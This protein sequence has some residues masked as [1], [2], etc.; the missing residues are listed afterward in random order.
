M[1]G[2]TSD[3]DGNYRIENVAVGRHNIKVSYIGYEDVYFNEIELIT[4][5]ELVLNVQMTEDISTLNEV[6]IK[7][8]DEMGEPINSMVTLSAQ[9]ITIESTSRIAA[10][11]NDPA[12]TV[13]SFAG[14]SSADDE[15]N[16]LVVRGNSPRGMLWRMEGVEIPNPNHFSNGEGGSGGG[17]S[18]LST[19]VLDNSD[20]YTGAFASEYGN[21]LSGVFD[22]RLRN[23]NNEKHQFALQLGVMGIQA[24]AEGPLSK[25]SG[26]SY[27]FNYRYATTSLLNE[28]GFTIGDEDIY[29]EWQDL[30]FNVNI[31][32]KKTGQVQYLGFGR[33]QR[34]CR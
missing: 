11:I 2:G 6:V 28:I 13:Q 8:E 15:N 25:E 4:G 10:G 33:C 3:Y 17:V 14:V 16:E 34:V 21:A 5:N 24:S 27:L 1:L 31:P 32:T 18:A 9:R 26:A 29:P 12:R 23:G 7:A 22:L 30:S 19:Q 20:F